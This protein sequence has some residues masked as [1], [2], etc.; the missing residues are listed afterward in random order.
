MDAVSIPEN[1]W[2]TIFHMRKALV[3]LMRNLLA[4]LFCFRSRNDLESKP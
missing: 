1:I 2:A 3:T 4:R